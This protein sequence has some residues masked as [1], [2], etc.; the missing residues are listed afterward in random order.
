MKTIDWAEGISPKKRTFM[1]GVPFIGTQ[2]MVI[3]EA[4]SLLEKRNPDSV[5]KAWSEHESKKFIKDKEKVLSIAKSY[6]NW[7]NTLF[8]PED[9]AAIIF[10]FIPGTWIDPID[11]LADIAE[12]YKIDWIDP[13]DIIAN[14]K[15]TSERKKET[16]VEI[17]ES[18]LN[19]T[20]QDFLN[21]LTSNATRAQALRRNR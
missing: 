21:T 15:E 20:L 19:D 1:D 16:C 6:L 10:G 13:T 11:I 18:A 4:K 2:A 8:I 17:Y 7:P 12:L 9:R 5:M 3:K 14:L